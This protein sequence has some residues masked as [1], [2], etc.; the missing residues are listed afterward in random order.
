[1]A[2]KAFVFRIYTN[3]KQEDLMNRTFGCC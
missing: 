2:N 1:M 3:K